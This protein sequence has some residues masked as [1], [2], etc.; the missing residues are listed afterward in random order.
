MEGQALSCTSPELLVLY[1]LSLLSETPVRTSANTSLWVPAAQVFTALSALKSA[2]ISSEGEL[3]PVDSLMAEAY[4]VIDKA[5]GK[6]VL[7]RNTG[8]R[9]CGAGTVWVCGGGMLWWAWSGV[10]VVGD[11]RAHLGDACAVAV[12]GLAPLEAGQRGAQAYLRSAVGQA[13]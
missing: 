12:L 4:S 13:V 1:S 3:K 10:A 8:A 7:H 2:G 6:G 5:V 9:R 11:A